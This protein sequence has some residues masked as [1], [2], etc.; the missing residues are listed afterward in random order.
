[1]SHDGMI[2]MFFGLPVAD[3]DR[4]KLSARITDNKP[5]IS[6][7]VHWT[8]EGQCHLTVRFIAQFPSEKVAELIEA[9]R[10]I[11]LPAVS[12]KVL[13]L[14]DFPLPHGHCLAAIIRLNKELAEIFHSISEVLKNFDVLPE[15]RPFKPHITLAKKKKGYLEIAIMEKT[16]VDY[17]IDVKDLILYQSTQTE[18]GSLYQQLATFSLH[19]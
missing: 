7:Y 8:K 17:S 19:R 10:S 18:A 6:E 11:A 3:A 15:K 9:V 1:M 4:Q 2:R 13:H 5:K 12:L 16:L 14:S